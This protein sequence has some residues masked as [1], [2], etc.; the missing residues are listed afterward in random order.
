VKTRICTKIRD[1]PNLY[2][3]FLLDEVYSR[4]L[5]E[6]PNA[7]AKLKYTTTA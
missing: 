4:D 5:N 1:V 3:L 7:V 2:R 6:D